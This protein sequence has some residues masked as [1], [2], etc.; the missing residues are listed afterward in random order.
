MWEKPDE[1]KDIEPLNFDESSLPVKRPPPPP[2]EVASHTQ[3][4][5]S[6]TVMEWRGLILHCLRKL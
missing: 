3:W 4:Y 6:S 1:G 5:W 2:A